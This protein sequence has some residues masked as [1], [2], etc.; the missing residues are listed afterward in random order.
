MGAA[1]R[2]GVELEFDHGADD[3]GQDEHGAW[4]QVGAR[5]I[6]SELI[7]VADGARSP[8]A[9]QLGGRSLGRC[10][11]PVTSRQSCGTATFGGC[12]RPG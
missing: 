3:L 8:S 7:V 6:S 1:R 2:A 10:P 5:R 4:T 12:S 9:Q 11:S